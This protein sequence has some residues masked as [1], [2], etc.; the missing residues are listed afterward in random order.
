MSPLDLHVL[1]TPP[2]FVLSQD[3]TLMFN[4]YPRSA[5]LFS[6]AKGLRS[7]LLKAFNSS[8]SDCSSCLLYFRLCIVFKDPVV[9]LSQPEWLRSREQVLLYQFPTRLS[10]PFST[11]LSVSCRHMI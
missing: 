5:F 6:L 4:P 9:R 1:S 8:K 2:A 7:P 3:Q 10:T 11:F